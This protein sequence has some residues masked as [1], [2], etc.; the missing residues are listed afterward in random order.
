MFSLHKHLLTTQPLSGP[1]RVLPPRPAGR[2]RWNRAPALPLL[3][4]SHPSWRP[5]YK[6]IASEGDRPCP[7]GR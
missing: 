4:V 3:P 6:K 2:L 7:A 5:V 1:R